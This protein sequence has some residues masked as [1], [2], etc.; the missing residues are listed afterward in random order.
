M[1]HH[2]LEQSDQDGEMRFSILETVREYALEQLAAC[3]AANDLRDR[4]AGYYLAFAE[5]ARLNLFGPQQTVCVNRLAQEYDNLRAALK[6]AVDHQKVEIALRLGGA[7]GR[8]WYIYDPVY[9][10]EGRR[11]L[12]QAL[13]LLT[14]GTIPLDFQAKALN[15]AGVLAWAQ[16][17]YE[18]A[19]RYFEECL[20]LRKKLGDKAGIGSALGNLGL[21]AREQLNPAR[22]RAYQEENL[23]LKRELGDKQG[24]ATALSNLGLVATDQGDCDYAIA[25][26]EESIALN[27]ELQNK[28][29]LTLTLHNLGGLMVENLGDFTRA[30]ALLEESLALSQELSK[31]FFLI[32]YTL[33]H[34]GDLALYQNDHGKAR[35]F[36]EQSLSLSRESENKF[37]IGLVLHSLGRLSYLEGDDEKAQECFIQSVLTLQ[38]VNAWVGIVWD[39]IIMADLACKSGQPIRAVTLLAASEKLREKTSTALLLA[40]SNE[41]QHNIR[42]ARSQLSETDFDRGWAEGRA[43]SLDQAVVYAVGEGNPSR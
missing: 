30:K 21:V 16:G 13:N 17:D 39:F 29:G 38:E 5:N 7:L 42:T 37:G 4:H 28:S 26:N 32:P 9:W 33:N 25:L 23:A 2:L 31:N 11:W 40:K 41:Y 1:D 10:S 24:I 6:W 20:A 15:E 43:M 8:F 14:V 12:E 18:Q 35:N 22:A 19:I 3:E 27:R 34:L 36:F